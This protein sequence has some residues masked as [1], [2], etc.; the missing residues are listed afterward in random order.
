MNELELNLMF[1]KN[2]LGDDPDRRERRAA[3]EYLVQHADESYPRILA[4]IESRPFALDAPALIQ[5]LPMFGREDS[6]D[7]LERIL[8]SGDDRVC[9]AAGEAL[10]RHPSARALDAL[11]LALES[12][13]RQTRI[14]AAIGLGRRGDDSVCETLARK[15]SVGDSV[16][17]YYI[18]QALAHIGCDEESVWKQ[19][20]QDKE[21]D[22]R[23]LAMKRRE[24]EP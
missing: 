20:E 1:L 18:A 13:N 24:E 6:V 12:E 14:G 21:A 23:A 16:E 8:S 10:G 17:R 19:L 5:V 7:L 4:E 9:R 15:T 3:I 2:W 11:L 22:I